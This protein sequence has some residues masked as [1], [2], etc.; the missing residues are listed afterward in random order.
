MDDKKVLYHYG[1][2]GM[3]WG[4]R[5]YQNPD[6]SLTPEGKERYRD[7][8]TLSDKEL[9]D[10]IRRANLEKQYKDLYDPAKKQKEERVKKLN[11]RAETY[12]AAGRVSK[13]YANVARAT[14]KM[15]ELLPDEVSDGTKNEGKA[16]AIKSLQYGAAGLTILGSLEDVIAAF[17]DLESKRS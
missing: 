2:L 8:K 14:S 9:Q 10:G 3:K 15:L 5:R 6:G 1:I 11:K 13:S 16:A 17:H 4:V 12:R 7:P